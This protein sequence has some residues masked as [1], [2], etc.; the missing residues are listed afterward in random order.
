MAT[1]TL[2]KRLRLEPDPWPDL[3]HLEQWDTPKKY[4][5]NEILEDG[6]PVPFEEYIS[7][8]GDP[9]N[10][11]VFVVVA[12]VRCPTCGDWTVTDSLGGV[13][14]YT[15]Q[16]WPDEGPLYSL[17]EITDPY[18]RELFE[19]MTFELPDSIGRGTR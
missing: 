5:G 19:S 13:D 17:D 7:T 12:E 18:L 6:K 16:S 9:D 3:S 4:K 1:Q 14:F 2:E 11:A 8:W 10:Y 15:P